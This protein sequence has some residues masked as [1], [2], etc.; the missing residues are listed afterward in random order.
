MWPEGESLD[1]PSWADS[2]NVL[3]TVL[4]HPNKIYIQIISAR[5]GAQTGHSRRLPHLLRVVHRTKHSLHLSISPSNPRSSKRR[6][7]SAF[8]YVPPNPVFSTR[9]MTESLPE[10]FLPKIP[11]TCSRGSN[12]SLRC[13]AFLPDIRPYSSSSSQN[14]RLLLKQHIRTS[15]DHLHSLFQ[16]FISSSASSTSP[17]TSPD[18]DAAHHLR[19]SSYLK[20]WNSSTGDSSTSNST[21]SLDSDSDIPIPTLVLQCLQTL[22]DSARDRSQRLNTHLV[23]PAADDEEPLPILLFDLRVRVLFNTL[24]RDYEFFLMDLVPYYREDWAEGRGRCLMAE[25]VGEITKTE[26]KLERWMGKVKLSS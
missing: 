19:L 7:R 5:H 4:H 22:V 6:P 15:F 17:S 21:T 14:P 23:E 2:S 10:T 20:K 16:S 11:C 13:Y 1:H 3:K 8:D 18:R 9:D 25:F 12:C 24:I 26:K